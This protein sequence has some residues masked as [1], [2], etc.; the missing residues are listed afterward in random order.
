VT[1]Q[2][3]RIQNRQTVL[4][5]KTIS[6]SLFATNGGFDMSETVKWIPGATVMDDQIVIRGGSGW[7]YG[8]GS[9][10]LLLQDGLPIYSGD[11]GQGQLSFINTES[12]ETVEIIK[13]PAS[14]IYGSSALNGVVNFISKKPTDQPETNLFISSGFYDKAKRETLHMPN[15]GY[16]NGIRAYHLRKIGKV[17]INASVNALLD[18]G[19]REGDYENR[20]IG[21]IGA[22][23]EVSKNLSFGLNTRYYSAETGSFL[24]WASY[25]SAYTPLNGSSTDNVSTKLFVDPYFKYQGKKWKHE[26]KFRNLSINNDVD[27]GNDSTDQSNA[28]NSFFAFHTSTVNTRFGNVLI[29]ASS[30]LTSTQSPLFSGTQRSSALAGFMQYDQNFRK[31]RFLAGLRYEQYTLN[32]IQETKPIIRLGINHAFNKHSIIRTSFG[33]GYRFPTIAESYISTAVGP[34][35][36]YPNENLT[37]ES[38]WNAEVGYVQAFKLG[39]IKGIADLA[40]FRME[41]DNM[42][43]FIFS[44][45]AQGT[46]NDFGLGFKSV[47]V[48]NTRVDGLET[49][50]KLIRN[51]KKGKWLAEF[52][53]L[54]INPTSL[55]PN[56]AF[57]SSF[58]KTPLTHNNTSS[59]NVNTLKYRYKHQINWTLSVKHQ[60]WEVG[61]RGAY[62]SRMTNIDTA[63]LAFPI[64]I[65]VPGI[66]SA[67]SLNLT[68]YTNTMM[69]MNYEISDKFTIGIT[70]QNLFN[71]EFMLRPADIGAPRSWRLQLNYRF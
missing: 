24:L 25:D 13:G 23:Y 1:A 66:D 33:Q 17:G 12:L 14:V 27:D 30:T 6:P 16:S 45:W 18:D 53:Y 41:F 60:K 61:T 8:A 39:K 68:Q 57:D 51:T 44:Q 22:E 32:D 62:F 55:Q 36:I 9:R 2:S 48:G 40:L 59:A 63:F 7:S 69:W 38:G 42:M 37:S 52:G 47:N 10:V 34:V 54:N 70:V 65:L 29:G 19:Y 28:S 58:N 4:S 71:T 67:R 46:M 3:S 31:W 50:V 15:T 43:E 26:T 20:I 64:N 11:A 56:V 35:T 49:S 21:Q 5:T